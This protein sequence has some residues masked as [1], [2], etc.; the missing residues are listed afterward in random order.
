MSRPSRCPALMCCSASRSSWSERGRPWASLSLRFGSSPLRPPEDSL[1]GVF[2]GLLRAF[3]APVALH[4][5]QRD[6]ALGLLLEHELGLADRARLRD[7]A[8]PRDEVT[9]LL[10]PV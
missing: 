5:A 10:R 6:A 7:R 8:I 9:A 3:A 1:R 4:A 2:L